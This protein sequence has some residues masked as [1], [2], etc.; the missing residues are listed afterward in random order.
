[1]N[2]KAFSITCQMCTMLGGQVALEQKL[3]AKGGRDRDSLE[4]IENSLTGERQ[5]EKAPMQLV[6][7]S[8]AYV[9]IHLD[10]HLGM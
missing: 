6:S 7:F 2:L 8:R 4:S 1:M 5:G 3:R 10:A 9:F